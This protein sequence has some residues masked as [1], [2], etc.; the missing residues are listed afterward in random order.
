MY[1]ILKYLKKEKRNTKIKAIIIFILTLYIDY[2]AIYIDNRFLQLAMVVTVTVLVVFFIIY[3][4]L[5]QIDDC[6][7]EYKQNFI[8][9]DIKLKHKPTNFIDNK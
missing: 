6:I 3:K 5:T 9:P 4:K 1:K 8:N 7:E 2:N